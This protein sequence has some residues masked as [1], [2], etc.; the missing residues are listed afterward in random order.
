MRKRSV[1]FLIVVILLGSAGFFAGWTGLT[2]PLGSVGVLR[3]KTHGVDPAVIRDGAFR[4]VWYRLIPTNA[5]II[6]FTLKP[7]SGAAEISGYLPQGDTYKKFASGA[8][9]EWRL[10]LHYTFTVKADSLPVLVQEKGIDSPDD[11]D[12]HMAAIAS[13]IEMD[14]QGLAVT[15][16]IQRVFETLASSTLENEIRNAFPEIDVLELRWTAIDTPD[17]ALYETGKELYNA[18][19]DRQRELLEPDA[20]ME[21]ERNVT[22]QF[23][24]DELER[25]G[26]L[27]AKYPSLLEYMQLG[28]R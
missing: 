25:Y 22:N 27:F 5:R 19:L 21:A 13:A 28:Q 26:E 24:F 23:R 10:G 1:F 3:S 4:W 17:F 14:A 20:Q 15:Q 12:K 11:L 8:R 18:Y 2:L 6:P 9:F 7:L 16:E